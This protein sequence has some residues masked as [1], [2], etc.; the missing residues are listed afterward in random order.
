MDNKC[1]AEFDSSSIHNNY[2]RLIS[3]NLSTVSTCEIKNF[4]NRI[5]FYLV[6]FAIIH[7]NCKSKTVETKINFLKT[8]NQILNSEI[9]KRYAPIKI[10]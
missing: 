1:D 6:H 2:A 9:E 10:F 3:M 7:K 4:V 5:N 8:A